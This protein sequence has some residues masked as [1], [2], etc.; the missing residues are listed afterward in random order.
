[1]YSFRQGTCGCPPASPEVRMTP[2]RQ[3]ML[4]EHSCQPQP[5][6]SSPCTPGQKHL[7]GEA[8]SAQR[9]LWTPSILALQTGQ[10]LKPT[11]QA[12]HTPPFK[13]FLL[14][15]RETLPPRTRPFQ[16]NDGEEGD[17]FCFLCSVTVTCYIRK[18]ELSFGHSYQICQK[19]IRDKSATRC[20][21]PFGCEST[22][23]R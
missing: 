12:F 9:A 1:M 7:A 15:I 23:G 6:I 8:P 13:R 19:Q 17:I 3:Q 5:P 22:T 16:L 2:C 10:L 14:Q 20:F 4:P 18:A 11:G 21:K